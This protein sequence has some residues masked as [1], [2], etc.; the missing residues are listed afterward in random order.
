MTRD[1]GYTRYTMRI[2]TDLYDRIKEA[3]GEKSVNA[4]VLGV[5]M[6]AFPP[7]K[8]DSVGELLKLVEQLND[9]VATLEARNSALHALKDDM[10]RASTPEEWA[11]IDA[12]I[13]AVEK[14]V[15]ARRTKS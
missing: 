15:T 9:Q 10:K 6:K 8:S 5:L 2:P 13:E 1:D 4:E 3:A 11:A 14:A 12:R 7:P